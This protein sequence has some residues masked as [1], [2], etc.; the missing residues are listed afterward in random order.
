MKKLMTTGLLVAVVLTVAAPTAQA[1][2]TIFGGVML[3][4]ELFG[5]V[6]KDG[7]TGG[8]EFMFPVIPYILKIGAQASFSYAEWDNSS[9]PAIIQNDYDGHW[10]V[11]E[12]MAIARAKL[13]LFPVYAKAG[14]GVNRYMIFSDTIEYD[15]E[16]YLAGIAGVG[17]RL[18][19]FDLSA[20]YHMVKWDEDADNP[21]TWEE[22]ENF[23]KSYSYVTATIG[24]GF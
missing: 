11:G 3:P 7:Y 14:L 18:L 12:A 16:T 21:E 5:G 2:T 10:G 8:L 4:Q 9:L 6:C 1:E 20:M 22:L 13:P 17:V 15:S 19:G 23:D 24:I